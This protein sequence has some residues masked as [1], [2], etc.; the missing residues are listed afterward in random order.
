M[1]LK[2]PAGRAKRIASSVEML[3]RSETIHPQGRKK[4]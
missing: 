3:E 2:A 4:R 1:S